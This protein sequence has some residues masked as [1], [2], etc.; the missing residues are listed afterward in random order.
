M[1]N[2]KLELRFCKDTHIFMSL[3]QQRIFNLEFHFYVVKAAAY[4]QFGIPVL[5][6]FTKLNT[7]IW[8][9]GKKKDI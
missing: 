1:K 9:A 2:L 7:A 4:F 5:S 6:S 3:K 8:S